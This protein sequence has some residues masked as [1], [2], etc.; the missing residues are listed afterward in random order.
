MLFNILPVSSNSHFVF[1]VGNM[2]LRVVS[3]L[4]CCVLKKPSFKLTS[5]SL[6][7]SGLALTR[8]TLVIERPTVLHEHV[9]HS[10]FFSRLIS[11]LKIVIRTVQMV[12]II[13][14]LLLSA[15]IAVYIKSFQPYWLNLLVNTIQTCGP[16][17]TKLGQWASTRRDLFP[18][19]LCDYLSRLQRNADVHGI[20]VYFM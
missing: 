17:Y 7:T 1:K 10:S 15:P 4:T 8:C 6:G 13:M 20:K 18:K 19:V 14:P 3:R 11:W 9:T 12:I 5:F 16:V 2:L